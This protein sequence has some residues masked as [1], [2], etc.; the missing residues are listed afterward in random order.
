MP[1]AITISNAGIE[2][3]IRLIRG[4]KVLLDED[5]ARLY[6][7][8][9]KRLNEA[10]KRNGAR[11]PEDFAFRL[12]AA[13]AA[14]L[15]SQI[16]TS[17]NRDPKVMTKTA[18]ARGGRHR[19]TPMA[20]T[21]QGVAMLSSVLSSPRAIA[22]NVGIMRAFVNM[23]QVMAV[24]AD[25][26]KRL[27]LLEAKLDQHRAESAKSGAETS[28]TLAEHEQHIRIVFETIRQLMHQGDPKPP[29]RVGF[30]LEERSV[31]Y[32][33]EAPRRSGGIT[34]PGSRPS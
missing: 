32:A 19:S 10:V 21:E 3:D 18:D 16:A 34:R 12:T 4:Q 5:L 20:F 30:R 28:K 33:A 22:V 27:A 23:R 15:K 6:G 25:L 8:E 9:T 7:V 1:K 2:R 14:V 26:A 31:R 11:F 29:A 17:K 13:E 24:N